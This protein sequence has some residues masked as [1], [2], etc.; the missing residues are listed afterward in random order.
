MWFVALVFAATMAIGAQT[1]WWSW[2]PA[3]EVDGHATWD[4][5]YVVVSYAGRF[6][7]VRWFLV[8]G[9]A[10]VSLAAIGIVLQRAWGFLLALPCSASLI[11]VALLARYVAIFEEPPQFVARSH[12][13]QDA[14][15]I[16]LATVAS[17]GASIILGVRLL[18][19]KPVRLALARLVL[20]A[21]AAMI[22]GVPGIWMY[23]HLPG[24]TRNAMMVCAC[25]AVAVAALIACCLPKRVTVLAT[26]GVSLTALVVLAVGLV[27]HLHDRPRRGDLYS[28]AAEL[29]ICQ[30]AVTA[31]LV[32]ALVGVCIVLRCHLAAAPNHEASEQR[33]PA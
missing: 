9:A 1:V 25:A 22:A 23:E 29:A 19:R 11:A 20:G 16:A 30:I 13:V 31:P 14:T 18:C 21:L 5:L 3:H 4:L 10:L 8:L 2:H 28:E 26:M 15:A 7:V 33:S 6:A 27:L 12:Y 32:V 24:G 17:H